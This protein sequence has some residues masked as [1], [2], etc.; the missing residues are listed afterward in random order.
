M[1]LLPAMQSTLPRAQSSSL[2]STVSYQSLPSSYPGLSPRLSPSRTSF[3]APESPGL[4]SGHSSPHTM[5]F[6]MNTSHHFLPSTEP[7]HRLSKETTKGQRG[8]GHSAASELGKQSFLQRLFGRK[9][10][11]EYSCIVQSEL[12]ERFKKFLVLA[13]DLAVFQ[14]W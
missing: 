4:R 12:L 13:V 14:G 6:L 2:Q 10:K 11:L 7:E 8:Y 1:S 3:T 9:K 5:P